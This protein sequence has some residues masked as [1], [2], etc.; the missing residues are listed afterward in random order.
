MSDNKFFRT[1]QGVISLGFGFAL[2]CKRLFNGRN[3]FEKLDKSLSVR[4][5]IAIGAVLSFASIE[6]WAKW[7][8]KWYSK[9]KKSDSKDVGVPTDGWHF[10]GEI[11]PRNGLCQYVPV[12]FEGRKCYVPKNYETYIGNRYGDYMKIPPAEKQVRNSYLKFSLGD[13]DKQAS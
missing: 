7:T 4:G 2:S 1:V 11:Y 12:S 6:K 3:S 10:F 13:Y 8:D 5:K 9:C